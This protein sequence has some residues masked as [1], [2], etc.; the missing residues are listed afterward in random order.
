MSYAVVENGAC[1][2]ISEDAASAVKTFESKPNSKLVRVANLEELQVA[3]EASKNVESC[4]VEDDDISNVL[5]QLLD[6]LDEN[7]I[8]AENAEELRKKLQSG[9]EQLVAEVRSLGIRGMRVVGDGLAALGDFMRIASEENDV[10][11]QST[12]EGSCWVPR[13]PCVTGGPDDCCGGSNSC[14][15]KHKQE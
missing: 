1:L 12:D 5:R 4:N 6:K 13:R 9:G 7:G 10:Q 11:A 14:E 2:H 8:N 15:H 3:V